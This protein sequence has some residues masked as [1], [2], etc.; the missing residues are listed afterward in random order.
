MLTPAIY[1]TVENHKF[2]GCLGFEVKKHVD[3]LSATG[4]VELPLKAMMK[5]VGRKY[6]VMIS[7]MIKYGDNIKIEAGYMED[8]IHTVFEGYITNIDTSDKVLVTVEDS[9]YLL[10][11]KPVIINKKDITVSDL[12]NELISG[13]S[14]LSVSSN[15]INATVDSFKFQG[16]AAA[17]LA[18]LKDNMKLAVYFDGNELY[19]GGSQLDLNKPEIDITYGR[20]VL[21]NDV[22]YQFADTNPV[23]VTVIGKKESGEEVRIVEG[24][25]G[26]TEMTFYKYNVTDQQALKQMAI[27]ELNRYSFD[28]FKGKL[29]LWFI[30]FAEVGGAVNYK[31]ENYKQE[32]EGKYFIKGVKY[33]FTTSKGLKQDITLGAKL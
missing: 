29:K 33:S 4:K 22:K 23:Q 3:N 27:N 19:A 17:A 14:G 28:G 26:G 6:S 12:C 10:R 31:N 5:N 16:N 30:P 32:T 25:E 21:K 24:M 13:I 11:K 9:L 18:A 8:Y 1:I 15:T 7:D 20:N 2:Y